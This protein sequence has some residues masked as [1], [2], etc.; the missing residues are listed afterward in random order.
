MRRKQVLPICGFVL[1]GLAGMTLA[2]PGAQQPN[3]LWIYV[4]DQNPWYGAYGESLVETPNIDALAREGVVFER[5][6]AATPVCSPSRS[7]Q[8]TGSYPIRI[9]AHDH[10]SSRVPYAEIHLPE[11]VKTVPEL[12]RQA[13]YATYN[14]GKDDYNFVYDRSE[15][16][17]I[18][19]D[20]PPPARAKMP[21]SPQKADVGTGEESSASAAK[22]G[23]GALSKDDWKGPRGGGDWRD[24]ADGAP[25]F[26][27]HGTTG[28]KAGGALAAALPNLGVKPVDPASVVVPPQYPDIPDIRTR[29]AEHLGTV[30]L[31]DHAV[32]ELLAR[33]KA[34]GHWE[35]TV[36]FLFGDHGSDLPRGKEYC[37]AEG[38]HAPLIIAAPGLKDIVKPGTRRSDIVSLIDVAATSLALAGLDIPDFMDAKNLFAPDYRRQYVFSSQDRMSNMIDRVRSVMGDRFHYI[39]NFMTDRSLYQFGYREMVGWYRGMRA[40]Y[41]RG[42]LTRAQAAPYGSRPAEELYDLQNDPDE[43]VNLTG[44]AAYGEQ[45]DAMRAALG[46]WIADTDDK[47]QY[48]RSDATMR[49]IVERFPEEWLKGPEFAAP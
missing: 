35:N 48:P 6:Y 11:N 41:E 31:T 22:S 16:Y 8:I 20:A 1:A 4:E 49:E 23:G 25:F 44:E 47:G 13:G 42:E 40:M 36:V 45:L 29:I 2:A 19:N 27:Q 33:L 26:G 9:G 46:G 37:Y 43:V 14:R 3:I 5:A 34:D 10:R 38:L 28:G 24:V 7:A 39:R 32:G 21:D 12:F 15:L 30:V 17:S 18:G